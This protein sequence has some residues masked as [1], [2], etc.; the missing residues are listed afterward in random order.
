[1]LRAHTRWHMLRMPLLQTAIPDQLSAELQ[2]MGQLEQ[3]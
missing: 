1:M 2:D 3:Q